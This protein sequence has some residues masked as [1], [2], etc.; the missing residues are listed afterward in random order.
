MLTSSRIRPQLVGTVEIRSHGLDSIAVSYVSI[1]LNKYEKIL[2]PSK[3]GAPLVLT[4]TKYAVHEVVG[5][6]IMLFQAP[7]GS[8]HQRISSLDLPF[9]I[10]IPS[11][12]EELPAASLILPGGICETS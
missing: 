6:E 12:Y 4:S 9:H 10:E 7:D 1:S 11:T 8:T 3:S 5:R 2:T